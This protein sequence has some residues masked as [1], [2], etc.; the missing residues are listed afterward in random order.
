MQ[1]CSLNVHNESGI[2]ERYLRKQQFLSDSAGFL[3][4][5]MA[6]CY[7]SNFL[8]CVKFKSLKW[9]FLGQIFTIYYRKSHNAPSLTHRRNRN[10]H[11]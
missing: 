5:Q 1:N 4:L 7:K 11:V 9:F 2:H 6:D 8:E 10:P 3:L